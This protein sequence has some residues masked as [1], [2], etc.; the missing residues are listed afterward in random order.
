MNDKELVKRICEGDEN[1]FRLLVEKYQDIVFRT[2]HGFLKNVED[3]EDL[4]Q[5]VFI[6][7]FHKIQDFRGESEF[8]TW[9]YRIAVNM[10]INV[11]RQNK[12]RQLFED[13]ENIIFT[14]GKNH[15]NA[16]TDASVDEQFEKKQKEDAINAAIDGLPSKQKTAFVLHKYDDLSQIEIAGIMKTSVSA[17][18]SLIHRAKQNL[19]QKLI[20]IYRGN[21]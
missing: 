11:L 7:V 15:Q 14:S 20:S 8:S 2:C 4:T 16:L 17:V 19:Q 5:E 13:I 12:R 21:I 9:L 6:K 10:S 18:E 3:S 1:S